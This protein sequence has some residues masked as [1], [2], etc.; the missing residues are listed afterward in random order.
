MAAVRDHL[1]EAD[2]DMHVELRFIVFEGDVADEK[3][4]LDLLVERGSREF[5]FV[6]SKYSRVTF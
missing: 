3:Y 6:K 4:D 5:F 2:D 1:G